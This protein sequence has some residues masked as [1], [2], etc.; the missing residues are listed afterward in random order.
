[1]RA[2][3]IRELGKV[4][5]GTAQSEKISWIISINP[6]GTKPPMFFVPGKGGY[7]TRIWHLAKR[8]DP[9]VPIYAFQNTVKLSETAR[10]HTVV[11][12]ARQYLAEMK[13]LYPIGPFLLVGESMGGKIVYEIAQQLVRVGILPQLFSF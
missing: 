13:T 5:D 4:V 11:T 7:P 3:T 1:M 10:Q 8:M 9:E 6:K 2:P 12:L